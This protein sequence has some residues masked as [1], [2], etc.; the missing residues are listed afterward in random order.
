MWQQRADLC[1]R[2]GRDAEA[3]AFADRGYAAPQS[4]RDRV[5]NECAIKRL[6]VP[7]D[8]ANVAVFLVS[9]AARHVTGQVIKVD[10]GQYL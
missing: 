3:E 7:T 4:A 10:A 5:L 6:G 8:I 1:R 2:L 9:E